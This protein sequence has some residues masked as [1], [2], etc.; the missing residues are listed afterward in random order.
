MDGNRSFAIFLYLD[1]G[2]QW[3]TGYRNS[4]NSGLGGTEAQVGYDA[5]D[6]INYYT[7]PG[8]MNSNIV[9]IETTSNV[10]IPG[11][12]L[13]QVD[14][15]YTGM[16]SAVLFN[17]GRK[18]LQNLIS[19]RHEPVKSTKTRQPTRRGWDVHRNALLHPY[20][21]LMYNLTTIRII[22]LTVKL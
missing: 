14:G 1:D 2:I 19:S 16:S 17:Y 10:G 15:N 21:T 20:F 13:F 4:G 9:D 5:G 18:F 6:Y 3:T 22:P 12:Y 11:M 7:V 8:S